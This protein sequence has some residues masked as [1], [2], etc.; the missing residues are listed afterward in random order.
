MNDQFGFRD[1]WKI[2]RNFCKPCLDRVVA[3]VVLAI[4]SPLLLL[5]AILIYLQM[6]SPIVF[7]QQRPGKGGR[8]FTCYKLRTMSNERD[9]NGILLPDDRRLTPL[10]SFLRRTSLDELPQLWSVLKGQMSFVGPRPLLIKY[11]P[12]Y[13]PEESKRH[14][15]LPGITGL[16]QIKGRNR[17]SWEER[18]QCDVYYVENQSFMLD[19]QILFLT[20]W[21]VIARA[22]ID[23]VP[24]IEDF[25]H[26]RQ[27]Q[28]NTFPK[29]E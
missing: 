18:L 7:T 13:S 21:K 11:L 17:L 4:L 1:R 3:A 27:R 6:G 25:D 22:D 14:W 9:R 5:T 20:I 8:L 16:A 19:M 28:V 24:Q 2:Y 10:G 29:R 23:V 26:Y 15:V 12:Y